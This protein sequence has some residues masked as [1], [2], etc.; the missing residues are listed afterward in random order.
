MVLSGKESPC[1]A[2]P[3]LIPGSE[4]TP[5]KRAWQPT[6]GFLPGE[7]HGQRSLVGHRESDRTEPAPTSL[8]TSVSFSVS[9]NFLFISLFRRVVKCFQIILQGLFI[10]KERDLLPTWHRF[11]FS[12]RCLLRHFW[13]HGM[14]QSFRGPSDRL[15]PAPCLCLA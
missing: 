3:G 7:S 9:V 11:C 14:K 1:S 12:F 15:F 2:A 6:P 4:K 5:W 8:S 10:D 13:F